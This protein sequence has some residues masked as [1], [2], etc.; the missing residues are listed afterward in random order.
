MIV[1][2][3]AAYKYTPGVT[4]L[5]AAFDQH[6]QLK[7]RSKGT[8]TKYTHALAAFAGWAGELQPGEFT[9]AEREM[10]LAAW[11]ANFEAMTGRSPAMATLKAQVTALRVFYAYL[12]RYDLLKNADGPTKNAMAL[13]EAPHVPQKAI[14]WLRADEDEALL[15]AAETEAEQII[16]SLLRWTGLRIDE[17]SSLLWSDIHVTPGVRRIIV[18]TSKTDA[19]YRTVPMPPQL[20]PHI[21]AWMKHLDADGRWK[22]NSPVLQTQTGRPMAH[23]HIGRVLKRVAYRAG[24]RPVECSCGSPTMTHHFK[25]CAQSMSGE[26]RSTISAHTMRRTYG[27][28]LLNSGVR[29]EV[30]SKLLGHSSTTITEQAYA[31]L[32]PSTISAELQRVMGWAA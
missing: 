24:V 23:T 28:H 7:G 4:D 17:A 18:R 12:D 29:I 6:L 27:S 20:V 15:A 8:R 31:Q 11:Q 3:H 1:C 9:T 30:V 26:Y 2:H 32:L 14:D 21:Y 16:V 13:I 25:G 5:A 19:G 22:L 10:Y